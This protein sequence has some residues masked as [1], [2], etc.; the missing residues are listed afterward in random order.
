MAARYLRRGL[1]GVLGLV[2]AVVLFATIAAWRPMGH[3][4]HGERRT[5][6]EQSAQWH[7]GHF[8]NPQ[9][10]INDL[11]GGLTA[12]PTASPVGIPSAAVPVVHV[13][14]ARLTLWPVSGLRITWMGH[15]TTLVEIDG[16]RILLDPVW[17]T[18]PTPLAGV[19]PSRWYPPVLALDRLPPIDVVLISHD[20][21]DHLDRPTV[22]ALASTGARFIVPLGVGAHLEYWGVPS[23][24]IE[25]LDWWDST[26]VAAVKIVSVPARHA[27]GRM[28]LDKDAT[29]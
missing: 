16:V 15:S 6:M 1:L 4:A 3:L 21:Y 7:S 26:A 25:E 20:H 8:E 27:S 9:P 18:R 19:G 17:S 14:P 13:D 29:L 2:V 11:V 23:A 5:R 10:L 28:L 22:R 24:R 12:M